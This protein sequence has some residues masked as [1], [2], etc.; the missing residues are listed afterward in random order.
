MADKN[1]NGIDDSLERGYRPGQQTRAP[2][3]GFGSP[4]QGFVG[5]QNAKRAGVNPF[6]GAL[7][8]IPVVGL[9]NNA[10]RQILNWVGDFGR[11]DSPSDRVGTGLG[12]QLMGVAP[13]YYGGKSPSLGLDK[14]AG[15]VGQLTGL[16]KVGR[17]RGVPTGQAQRDMS[18]LDALMMA[19][20]M[21]PGASVLGRV[22]YDPQRQAAR[23]NASEADMRIGA[24]YKQLADSIAADQPGIQAA[25]QQAID[26]TN[27]GSQAAQQSVQAASDAASARNQ[28]VL[29]NLGIGDAN[30]QII[31]QGR[32]ANTAAAN[33]MADMAAAQQADANALTQN[34]TT[35]V[36][37]NRSIGSAAGLEGNL[38][39]AQNQAKLQ[40]LL[41]QIDMAEQDKNASIDAQNAQAGQGNFSQAM[42][43]AQALYGADQQRIGRQDDLARYMQSRQDQMDQ[44][45]IKAQGQ[46]RVN[47]DLG[48]MLKAL[49]ISPQD[50]ANDPQKYAP[51][52]QY[53]GKWQL[54]P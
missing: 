33:V 1:N 19:Q 10:H 9:Y 8:Q 52:L 4:Q 40:A 20:N 23:D 5:N 50:L 37:Q 46:Q 41:A 14:V 3:I 43:L 12:D 39:R 34:Q 18:F 26:A 42:S 24:M 54:T 48:T 27:N 36:Q 7:D 51:L 53:G 16:G 25:Y 15:A 32:D 21:I 11:T 22:N 47:P 38:Q 17:P 2:G 6:F 44:A 45:L 13:G 49:G 35:A 29:A 30:Q 31:A 28:S